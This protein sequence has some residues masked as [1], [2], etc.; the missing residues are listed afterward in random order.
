VKILEEKNAIKSRSSLAEI[1]DTHRQS[2]NEI[3]NEKRNVTIE[4]ISKL[5]ENFHVNASF[6]IEGT[7][8]HF[9]NPS[10][11]KVNISAVPVKAQAG[12]GRQINNAVYESEFIMFQI[13]GNHFSEG[14]FRCFEVEGDSMSPSYLPKDQVVCS[15]LPNVYFE[16]ALKNYKPYIIITLD[17]VLL[18]RVINNVKTSKSI[19]LLSD[20]LDYDPCELDIKNI[21][22]IWKVEGLITKREIAYPHN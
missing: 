5:C 4:L 16:Q 22:E 2:L 17:S 6:I 12:Y 9:N 11:T 13:P 3:F 20:N 7:L 8:P 21:L 10:Q 14:E 1:L 19:T 15:F 18:K